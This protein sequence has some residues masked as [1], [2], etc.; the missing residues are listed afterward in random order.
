[1]SELSDRVAERVRADERRIEELRYEQAFA[2]TEKARESA[3]VEADALARRV[4]AWRRSSRGEGGSS[5]PA[6][7][8]AQRRLGAPVEV[9][10]AP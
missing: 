1:M 3:A 2:K 6:G 10:S 5:A 9:T 8:G 4:R 7:D